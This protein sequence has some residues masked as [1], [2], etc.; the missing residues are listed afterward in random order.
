MKKSAQELLQIDYRPPRGDWMDPAVDFEARRG[1]WS[2]P[3]GPKSLEYM[4]FPN[5]RE[6]SPTD[7]DWKLPDGWQECV[8]II[9]NS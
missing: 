6:W 3:G 9:R 7:D 2:Y 5:P 1:S 4:G 8:P